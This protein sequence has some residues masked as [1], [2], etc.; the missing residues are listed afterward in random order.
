MS[1][2]IVLLGLAALA[3]CGGGS[4]GPNPPPPPPPPP[5][6]TVAV[7]PPTLALTVG[8]TGQLTA[9]V[10][11]SSAAVAWSSSASG[12]ATVDQAGLVTAVSAGTATITASL[13]GQTNIQGTSAVTVSAPPVSIGLTG[14][15]QNGQPVVLTDVKKTVTFAVDLTVPAA[16]NGSARVLLGTKVAGSVP[17][18]NGAVTTSS[19][20]PDA[21]AR[22]AAT[23]VTAS[24]AAATTPVDVVS[25]EIIERFPNGDVAAVLQVL[26][27]TQNVVATTP[28]PTLRLNN[29]TA[30]VVTGVTLRGTTAVRDGRTYASGAEFTI[31]S[32]NYG[33]GDISALSAGEIERV[34]VLTGPAQKVIFGGNAV[35]G[36][37]NVIL[38]NDEDPANGGTRNAGEGAFR[39]LRANATIGSVTGPVD[40]LNNDPIAGVNLPTA[41]WN[42]DALAPRVPFDKATLQLGS[43]TAWINQNDLLVDRLADAGLTW[44]GTSPTVIDEG[45]GGVDCLIHYSTNGGS[46]Y[47]TT[48]ILKGGDIGFETPSPTLRLRL[49]CTDALGQIRLQP[50]TNGITTTSQSIGTDFTNPTVTFQNSRGLEVGL[51]DWSVNPSAGTPLF[52]TGADA[53]GSGLLATDPYRVKV[54]RGFEGITPAQECFGGTF[55]TDMCRGLPLSL[56]RYVPSFGTESAEYRLKV[57]VKDRAFNFSGYEV[58]RVIRDV[59]DPIPSGLSLDATLTAGL[60]FSLGWTFTD[61]LE[62]AGTAYGIRYQGVTAVPVFGY[63][64][65]GTPFDGTWKKSATISHSLN[66]S[67]SLEQVS[68]GSNG[69]YYP[70]GVERKAAGLLYGGVDVAGNGGWLSADI[71]SRINYDFTSFRVGATGLDR[72]EFTAPSVTL[73]YDPSGTANCLGHPRS[74]MINVDAYYPTGG[75][76]RIEEMYLAKV[77]ALDGQETALLFDDPMTTTRQTFSGFFV[78]RYSFNLS[79]NRYLPGTYQLTYFGKDARGN[80]LEGRRIPYTVIQAQF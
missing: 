58:R 32:A 14:V 43:A 63:Q 55:I 71:A 33:Q 35:A 74:A 30:A 12:V 49:Q 38:R 61:D 6:P 34:E 24:I 23:L 75:V 50:I 45:A 67:A 26:D 77:S 16:F 18:V 3:A 22:S 41:G 19:G 79:G 70:N 4:T 72:I 46:T 27:A 73:C 21:P 64:A 59:T 76:S 37:I 28:G 42:L 54:L 65:Q 20:S 52:F 31:G 11:G 39:L 66:F 47:L 44:T 80:L 69:F 17:I 60:P 8:Q 1:R 78:D 9:T 48:P 13:T 57:G 51:G 62:V 5:P 2:P 25:G 36:V 10:T 40:I 7:A 15:T 29:G 56:D 53:G 68:L